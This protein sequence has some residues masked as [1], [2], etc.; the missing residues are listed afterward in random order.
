MKRVASMLVLL[1]LGCEGTP[2]DTPSIVLGPRVLGA[3]AEPPEVAPG[4]ELTMAIATAMAEGATV[5]WSADTSPNALAASAGQQLFEARDPVPLPGG[6]LDGSA[7]QAA[8]DELL[9]LVADAPANTPESVVRIVY[10]EVGLV[11]T[12]QF[13]VR[14][15]GGV[16]IAEGF[17][18]VGVVP[19]PRTTNPPPPRFSVGDRAASARLGDPTRCAPEGAPLEARAG[20][21]IVLAPEP[22]EAWLETYPALD[23]EG[24]TIEGV[25]NAY[26]SWFATDGAFQFAV[27]RAPEREVEWTAPD[28]PGEVTFWLVVRDGH[29]GTSWCTATVA[30]LP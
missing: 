22:D 20:E 12:V 15:A 21:T 26:Y 13:V 24:R 3:V 30:V 6:V 18:R 7:T 14:D 28:T 29:F 16:V 9:A 19:S 25:E 11:L 5:E 23:L 10:E 27:T 2:F 8:V 17:K 1:L 4:A